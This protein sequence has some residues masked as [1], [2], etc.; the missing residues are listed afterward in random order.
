MVAYT[1]VTTQAQ[2]A[3]FVIHTPLRLCASKVR[4]PLSLSRGPARLEPF[5]LHITAAR[6]RLPRE[7]GSYVIEAAFVLACQFTV[8]VRLQVWGRTPVVWLACSHHAGHTAPASAQLEDRA[9]DGH[10]AHNDNSPVRTCACGDEVY[11]YRLEIAIAI[12]KD[13]L[14]GH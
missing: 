8:R 1:I 6:G 4:R 12:H 9:C 13:F 14:D 2:T 5:S 11:A 10:R 3:Q 7:N